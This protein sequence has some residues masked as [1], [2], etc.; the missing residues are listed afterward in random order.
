M[1][2]ATTKQNPSQSYYNAHEGSFNLL[3]EENVFYTG[4]LK[5]ALYGNAGAAVIFVSVFSQKLYQC[6]L[7]AIAMLSFVIG[8]VLAGISYRIAGY[9][10]GQFKFAMFHYENKDDGKA[11]K[12]SEEGY[13][14]RDKAVW[15][16]NA[17][18]VMLFM[19]AVFAIIALCCRR[20]SGW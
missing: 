10:Q 6:H 9:A 17:S 3:K 8:Y 14:L 15:L 13:F 19:G 5:A 1:R 16:N 12:S 11:Q 4:T 7:V 20:H 18:F 2:E